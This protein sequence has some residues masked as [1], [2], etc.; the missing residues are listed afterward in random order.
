MMVSRD[1]PLRSVSSCVLLASFLLLLAIPAMGAVQETCYLGRITSLDPLSRT[2]SIDVASQYSCDYSAGSPACNFIPIVPPNQIAVTTPIVTGTVNSDEVFE[3]F[4]S[5][6]QVVATI[7]GGD[8]G[9]WIGIALASHGQGTEEWQATEL[10]GDPRSLPVPL[11]GDYRMEYAILPDCSKCSGSVCKGLTSLITVW[12]SDMKVVDDVLNS[13][14]S[15]EYSGRNDGSRVSIHYLS[16]E[17]RSTQC[18]QEDAIAGIQPVSSFIIHVIPPI[19]EQGTP[20]IMTHPTAEEYK[21]PATS[22]SIPAPTRASTGYL[23]AAGAFA[24]IALGLRRPGI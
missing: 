22:S 9:T 4:Q 1:N 10:Y 11:A 15:L 3:L 6:D 8:G 13:G 7:I 17:T 12:S 20:R 16:G 21:P 19:R 24:I 5:G 18:S 2:L 23:L 14:H